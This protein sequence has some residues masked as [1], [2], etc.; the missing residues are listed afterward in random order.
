MINTDEASAKD[1]EDL[2]ELAILKV[3]EKSGVELKW[4]IKRLGKYE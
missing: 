3:K 2:G 1:L 4:E